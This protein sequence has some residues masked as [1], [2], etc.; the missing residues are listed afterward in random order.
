MFLWPRQSDDTVLA[1]K[2][3]EEKEGEV[4]RN[5]NNHPADC[6]EARFSWTPV[7]I[8]HDC[9]V[10]NNVIK[11]MKEKLTLNERERSSLLGSIYEE[12]IKYTQ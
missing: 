5:V 1:E 11:R 4:D 3:G 8:I 6:G 7:F 9:N 10:R 2:E 12:C